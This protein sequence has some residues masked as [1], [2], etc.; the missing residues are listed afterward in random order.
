MLFC[1]V[2]LR[3]RNDPSR[4]FHE[5]IGFREVGQQDTDGGDKR[6]SLMALELHSPAS[7]PRLPERAG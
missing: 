6:V 3:P 5:A 2:N 7:T 1:E 4:E